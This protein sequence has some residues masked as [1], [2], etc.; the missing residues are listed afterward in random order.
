MFAVAMA[1]SG[2]QPGGDGRGAGSDESVMPSL[3]QK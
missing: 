3:G 2:T 1:C